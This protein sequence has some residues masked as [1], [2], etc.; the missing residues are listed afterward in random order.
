MV[1]SN[2]LITFQVKIILKLYKLYQIF[3]NCCCH[4]HINLQGQKICKNKTR[5]QDIQEYPTCPWHQQLEINFEPHVLCSI[6]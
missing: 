6:E 4:C 1:A 3:T 5:I 2:T